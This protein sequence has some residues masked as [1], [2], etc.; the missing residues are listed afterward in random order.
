MA[1]VPESVTMYVCEHC[2]VAHAG[3]P[4]HVDT[5]EHRFEAPDECGSCGETA[6][7]ALSDWVHHHD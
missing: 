4:I 5:A 1:H 3:T 7:V 6:F 2:Q